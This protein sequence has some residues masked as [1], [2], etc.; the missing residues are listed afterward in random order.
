MS[1]KPLPPGEQ[2]TIAPDDDLYDDGYSRPERESKAR[3]FVRACPL[4]AEPLDIAVKLL[5][6]G[7]KSDA[8]ETLLR[9][10]WGYRQSPPMEKER[11][12]F[13]VHLALSRV[14]ETAAVKLAAQQHLGAAEPLDVHQVAK[15]LTD[16][17]MLRRALFQDD[18]TESKAAK[19]AATPLEWR[20]PAEIPQREWIYKPAYIGGYVSLTTAAGGAGKSALVKAEA[21]AIASGKPL[22][23]ITPQRKRVWYWNGEDPAEEL[24]R[25]FAALRIHYGLQK[26]DLVDWL[27]VDSGRDTPIKI[28][29]VQRGGLS[30]SMPVAEA[31]IA[32]LRSK[33]IGVLVIDPFVTSHNVPENDNT[34]MNEVVDQWRAIADATGCALQLVHHTKKTN[35][36]AA[37]I[38]ASRGASAVSSAARVRRAI[39]TMTQ[40]EADAAGIERAE[41]F[42]Y[43]AADYRST[44]FIPGGEAIAWYRFESVNLGNGPCGDGDSIGVLTACEISDLNLREGDEEAA[45]EAI[46]AGGPWRKGAKSEAWVG[47]PIASAMGLDPDSDA[48]RK[49]LNRVIKDWISRGILRE[50]KT[51]D[52]HRND[53]T[54]ITAGEMEFG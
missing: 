54:N 9:Q 34:M 17:G 24:E 14:W 22:L 32:E 42:R 38:E 51:K 16:S 47:R 27:F 23:G 3:E 10:E 52:E 31:I 7:V 35:G 28:A 8:A 49:R 25:G 53:V 6:S 18:E 30:I 48:H 2:V 45:L 11:A 26:R 50:H 13:V 12:R 4:D 36:E 5:E 40:S 44:S 1:S 21:A 29:T 15:V 43:I 39:N 20:D 19:I 41:R 46:R 33:E 37:T